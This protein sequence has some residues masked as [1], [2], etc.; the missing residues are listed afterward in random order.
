MDIEVERKRINDRAI[1][2]TIVTPRMKGGF[3]CNTNYPAITENDYNNYMA[4]Y[5][6]EMK[7]VTETLTLT[8][9][10]LERDVDI[11]MDKATEAMKKI[12]SHV[13]GVSVE[14]IAEDYSICLYTPKRG[15]FVMGA[16]NI[17]EM[18]KGIMKYFFKRKLKL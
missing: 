16:P 8:E 17:M 11:F 5:E 12:L 14:E 3:G 18:K 1:A 15:M 13:R 10:F 2:Q 4:I 9:E 7:E 6:T